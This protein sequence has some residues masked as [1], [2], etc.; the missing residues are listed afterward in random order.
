VNEYFGYVNC[1]GPN[2]SLSK[3]EMTNMLKATERLKSNFLLTLELFLTYLAGSFYDGVYLPF[4]NKFFNVE[5]SSGSVIE[6]HPDQKEYLGVTNVK[7]GEAPHSTLRFNQNESALLCYLGN[8]AVTIKIVPEAKKKGV[9]DTNIVI[10]S[11][12]PK[13][14]G[15][16]TSTH[17]ELTIE[18]F[19][20]IG[21][22]QV[23]M[24]NSFGVL[25]LFDYSLIPIQSQ[26]MNMNASQSNNQ[27]ALNPAVLRCTFDINL[28]KPAEQH[29]MITSLSVY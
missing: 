11:T 6:I 7:G 28:N 13:G 26:V 1:E 10:K 9:Y 17:Q 5:N 21:N 14:R 20:A 8:D 25:D 24:A 18:D 19:E 23:I 2:N 27:V 12:P 4:K 29:E 22:N 15:V 16:N 3:Y